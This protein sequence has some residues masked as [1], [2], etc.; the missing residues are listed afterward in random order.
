MSKS[1]E[2]N[3]LIVKAEMQGCRIDNRNKTIFILD[4]PVVWDYSPQVASLIRNFGF[5]IQVLPASAFQSEKVYISGPIEHYDLE[6]RK[7][8]FHTEELCLRHL[9]YIPVNPFNNGLPQPGNWREHMNAD[10]RMLLDCRYITLLPGWEKSKGCRLE[11]DVAM[12]T[13]LEILNFG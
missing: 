2:L 5:H 4:G 11:L 3:E 7:A 13:G 6:E 1:K 10:I 9:G 12:S 8:T